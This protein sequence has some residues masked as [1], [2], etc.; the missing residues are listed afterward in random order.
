M[1]QQIT[2]VW[3]NLDIE[4]RVLWKEITDWRA[5]F[6]IWRQNQQAGG[7]IAQTELDWA[8]KHSFRFDSAQ[9]AFSNLGSVRQLRP[10]QRQR[11]SVADF[12]IGRAA[13]DLAFCSASIIDFANSQTISIWMTRRSSDLRNDHFVDVR[14]A[15]LDV[16]G[17]NPSTGQ[18]VGDL[19][20]IF[21]KINKFAQ[22]IDRKFH[23]NWRRNRKSFCAKRRMSGM[24]NR[25]IARRSMPRPNA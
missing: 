13:N 17:L 5:D 20:R 2:T 6:R 1:A 11:N 16:F 9:L 21:W 4:N 18:Q 25:I 8:A 15:R 10:R 19:F 14:A 24:S 3:R 7:I 22:P 23:A 12:V